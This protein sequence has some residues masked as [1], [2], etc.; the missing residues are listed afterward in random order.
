MIATAVRKLLTRRKPVAGEQITILYGGK[1]GNSAYIAN[2]TGKCL[3]RSG[4]RSR[5]VNMAS[6]N[7]DQLKSESFVLI[8][9]ST[10]GEGE[11]PPAASRFFRRLFSE[12]PDLYGVGYA[13]CALGDSSYE[14]FCKAGKD[15]DHR[16]SDLGAKRICSRADCDLDFGTAAS[17]WISSVL[18]RLPGQ[19]DGQDVLKLNAQEKITVKAVVKEKYQLNAGSEDAVY[20]ICL[21]TDDQSFRYCSGDS[22]GLVPQ[23]PVSLV[24]SIIDILNIS[25]YD[26]LMAD[27]QEFLARDYLLHRAELTTLNK[28]VLVKYAEMSGNEQL[29]DLLNGKSGLDAYLENHDVLDLLQDFPCPL[30]AV[31][32]PDLLRPLQP[33]YYS[34]SS[35]Q[36]EHP[37]ELHLTVKR[38]QFQLK[39]RLRQ[40][41]CS[42]YLSDWLET[43]AAVS[44]FLAPNDNF[45][46][47][48]KPGIPVIFIAA[49][50]GIAPVRAF[51]QER[52]AR[53]ETKNW[54][55]FGGK[56]RRTDFLYGAEILDFYGQQALERL[57]LAFSRD[58]Q[59]KVYVQDLLLQKGKELLE[60]ISEGAAIYVCGSIKMGKGVRET[61]T[62]L[63]T[64]A[65]AD[66]SLE[67]LIAEW[68]YLE[69]LY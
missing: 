3:Q 35:Y 61:L 43:G 66:M 55:F 5:V 38:V 41:S 58:G 59:A 44:F 9:V 65:A 52:A 16:L 1:S 22:V 31:W 47:P 12:Q 30:P 21:A 33:R 19:V 40:G 24:N 36:P 68:K 15:I 46:L 23:N 54:L 6:Y 60:W 13:V 39:N 2:E 29:L 51:L 10:H 45:R 56:N 57:D 7:M 26:L 37:G 32:L 8:V 42:A 62:D 28:E 49:G 27:Q 53:G 67:Q 64:S 11:P 18:R 14:H 34:V 4:R 69:D 17:G 20:H 63:F 25:A 50:T 48:G